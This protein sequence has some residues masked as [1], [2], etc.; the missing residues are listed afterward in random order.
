[1]TH[2]IYVGPDIEYDGA[3]D[4]AE[5]DEVSVYQVYAEYGEARV[6]TRRGAM[7]DVALKYLEM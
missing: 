7:M 3:V 6:T 1:M 5:G 2:A 4:L